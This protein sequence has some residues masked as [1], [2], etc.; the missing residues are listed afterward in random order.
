CNSFNGTYILTNGNG[1]TI[2]PLASTM[3]ACPNMQT[4]SELFRVME[5]VDNYTIEQDTLLLNTKT[6]LLAKFI[7]TKIKDK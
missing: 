7:A 5:L 3:V 2:S 6:E 4:E 1:I